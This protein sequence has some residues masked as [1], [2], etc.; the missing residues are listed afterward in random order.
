MT[1]G[2]RSDFSFSLQ[3]PEFLDQVSEI[4]ISK[5]RFNQVESPITRDE[6][7]QMRRCLAWHA[8]QIAI[9]LSAPGGPGVVQVLQ[10]NS[11]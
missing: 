7:K 6:L 11:G 3:Q 4:Y 8:G 2:Q 9:E 5:N 10:R 1:K